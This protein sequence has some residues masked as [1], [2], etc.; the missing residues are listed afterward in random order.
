[1]KSIFIFGYY[2][3]NLF[4]KN[5][6]LI[7]N[8]INHQLKKEGFYFP[9]WKVRYL[10][11]GT[12]NP[13]GGEAV[14]YYYGRQ[15]NQ[16]W[17]LIS[18]IFC[19]DFDTNSPNF[20]TLLR[21]HKIACV[22][23]IDQLKASDNQI[24]RIVGKG[25]KDSEIIKGSIHLSYNT[26]KIQKLIEA[27]HGVNVFSTWGKGPRLKEWKQEIEKLGNIEPLVSPSLAARVPKGEQKFDYMLADW[28]KKIKHVC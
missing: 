2:I 18:K 20:F 15:K 3:N 14:K 24:E 17:K 21:K 23:M 28:K 11:I 8:P 22:D 1:M 16:T 13:E 5:T 26:R 12:F 25:Y 4:I 9:E 7:M 10:F 19:D 6:R 27:N